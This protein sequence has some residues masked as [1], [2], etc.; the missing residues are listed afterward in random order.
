MPEDD[1]IP[2]PFDEVLDRLARNEVVD[3]DLFVKEHPD[4]SAEERALLYRLCR[5]G[6]SERASSATDSAAPVTTSKTAPVERIG[7]YRLGELI[8]AGGMGAVFQAW[9][10]TLGREV[11]V[12]IL[13][14]DLVG[15]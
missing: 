2:T 15:D 5:R 11:A 14:P 10:E 7:S 4:L 13:G 1:T 6:V 3:P 12:K 8:G 9:D